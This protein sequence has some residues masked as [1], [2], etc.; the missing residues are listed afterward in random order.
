VEKAVKH[1][2]IRCGRFDRQLILYRY[3]F[4]PYRTVAYT[5]QHE[6][7]ETAFPHTGLISVSNLIEL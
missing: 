5:S 3:C 6:Q 1:C 4:K 7:S 2:L